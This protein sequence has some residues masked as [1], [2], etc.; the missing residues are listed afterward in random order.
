MITTL[1]KELRLLILSFLTRKEYKAT[2][3]CKSLLLC[4]S[5]HSISDF[6]RFDE[7]PKI[8][9]SDQEK[10]KLFLMSCEFNNLRLTNWLLKQ[11]VDP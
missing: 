7:I 5:Y 10:E 3:P 6:A 4:K 1:P 11:G 2:V 8:S 9:L